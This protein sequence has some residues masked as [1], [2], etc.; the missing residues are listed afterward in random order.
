MNA[1]PWKLVVF[2]FSLIL[3]VFFIGFN[4]ENKMTVSFGVTDLINVPVF[5]ALLVAFVAGTLASLPFKLF[6]KN[7]AIIP[8][9]NEITKKEKEN[10]KGKK[11]DV[12]GEDS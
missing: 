3:G 6:P 5:F 11:D 7:K 12:V 10:E 4:L 9:K 1:F 2:V 8:A